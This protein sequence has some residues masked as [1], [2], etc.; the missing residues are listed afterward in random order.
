M[1]HIR[2][3]ILHCRRRKLMI[4]LMLGPRRGKTSHLHPWQQEQ[5]WSCCRTKQMQNAQQ[6]H[7]ALGPQE[8]AHDHEEL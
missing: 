4:H 5:S 6:S 1:F 2:P 7:E 8:T 3:S